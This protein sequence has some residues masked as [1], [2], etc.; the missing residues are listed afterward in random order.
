M[1]ILVVIVVCVAIGL[2]VSVDHGGKIQA[3]YNRNEEKIMVA[4]HQMTIFVITRC[5]TAS[6]SQPYRPN[7][8]SSSAVAHN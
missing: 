6:L 2:K 8:L 4:S 1:I 3:F 5:G 7:K